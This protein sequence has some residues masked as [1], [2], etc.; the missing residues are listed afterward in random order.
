MIWR[1]FFIFTLIFLKLT[2]N[3]SS[4]N[5]MVSL[6]YFPL[7]FKMRMML[8][9]LTTSKFSSAT[10]SS[11]LYLWEAQHGLTEKSLM[12]ELLHSTSCFKAFLPSRPTLDG[13]SITSRTILNLVQVILTENVRKQW[14]DEKKSQIN[15]VCDNE[16]HGNIVIVADWRNFLLII[17]FHVKIMHRLNRLSN[18]CL[19][20]SPACI[21][22]FIYFTK[23][24]Y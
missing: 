6:S 23:I 9:L 5:A 1:N 12:A 11:L 13:T 4:I 8:L 14:F 18:F 21:Q 2:L 22:N 10:S 24:I 7:L 20:S 17:T 19:K 15:V 3:K 16:I